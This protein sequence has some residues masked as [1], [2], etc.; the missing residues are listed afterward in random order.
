MLEWHSGESW[1]H[2]KGDQTS[3]GAMGSVLS[4]VQPSTRRFPAHVFNLVQWFFLGRMWVNLWCCGCSVGRVTSAYSLFLWHSSTQRLW[5]RMWAGTGGSTSFIEQ[6]A[7]K[8]HAVCRCI[9]HH[10]QVCVCI[11]MLVF[12]C[13]VGERFWLF[14]RWSMSWLRERDNSLMTSVW[15]RRYLSTE[16]QHF[17]LLLWYTSFCSAFILSFPLLCA[18]RC[19][20]SPC[21]SWTSWQRVSLDRSLVH[22]TL[23]F[24]SIKVNHLSALPTLPLSPYM[25]QHNLLIS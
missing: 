15:S 2:C 20:T 24:L 6:S 16:Q 4:L 10:M 17:A 13:P 9:S 22:W 3:R 21:W 23:S 1:P 18:A 11:H 25:H 7:V 19:T 12:V 14:C 8:A 5:K